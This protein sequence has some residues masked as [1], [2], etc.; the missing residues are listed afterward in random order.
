[1]REIIVTN[2]DNQELQMN[3]N[4]YHNHDHS[5]NQNGN[6]NLPTPIEQM[7]KILEFHIIT[8]MIQERCWTRIVY[9][10]KDGLKKQYG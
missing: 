9:L 10:Q 2:R 8:F 7:L 4:H 3:Q 5:H 1:M 6:R